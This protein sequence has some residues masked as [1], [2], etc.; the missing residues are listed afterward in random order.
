MGVGLSHGKT[1]WS[2]GGFSEFRRRLARAHGIEI[3]VMQGW[4]DGDAPWTI[5]G[6]PLVPLLA[7]SDDKSSIAASD[8]EAC[9]TAI[10]EIVATWNEWFDFD[11]RSNGERLAAGMRECARLGIPL[12][13][14]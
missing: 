14:H 10:E 13:I 11:D 9:A 8:C 12:K 3:S 6:S 7:A 5:V 2:Y 4:G 1:Q